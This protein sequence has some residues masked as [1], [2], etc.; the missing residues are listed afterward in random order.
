IPNARAMLPAFMPYATLPTL[1]R[2]AFALSLAGSGVS[3]L[4]SAQSEMHWA[5]LS[6]LHIPANPADTFR[7]FKPQDN[8]KRIVPEILKADPLGALVCGDVA[9]LTGLT[10]DY[11][12]TRSLLQPLAQI[13]VD[14]QPAVAV[15]PAAQ[16]VKRAGDVDVAHV[17]MP[18]LMWLQ[19]LLEASAF[20]RWLPLPFPQ[21]PR[22]PQYPP[23]ARRAH[24]HDVGVQH[25][26]RQPAVGLQRILQMELDDGLL[27]PI[28]QLEISGNPAVVLVH[29]AVAVP[30]V[31]ELAGGDGR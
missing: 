23:H 30:A 15:Q 20:L 29:L 21:Q 19:W 1:S 31:V 8:L 9:R 4:R 28:L 17:G 7:G 25:H 2:R 11:E 24:R 18:M 13:P 5:L 16:L 27:L 6:D 22:F 10:A 3:L 14:D 26:E 12:A